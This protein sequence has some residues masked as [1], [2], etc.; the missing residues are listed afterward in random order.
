MIINNSLKDF[1]NNRNNRN[2][3]VINSERQPCLNKG[4]TLAHFHSSGKIP[5][6]ME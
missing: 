5:V 3:S 2:W 6:E 4:K 1:C